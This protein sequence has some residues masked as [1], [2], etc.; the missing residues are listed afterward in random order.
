MVSCRIWYHCRST[1]L[2]LKW[3][4]E[5]KQRAIFSR[6]SCKMRLFAAIDEKMRLK[7]KAHSLQAL[8]VLP[9]FSWQL[10]KFRVYKNEEL[11][12]FKKETVPSTDR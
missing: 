2:Q 4:N 7:S 8:N 9:R 11:H 6:D 1:N 5:P 12:L 3:R 10:T